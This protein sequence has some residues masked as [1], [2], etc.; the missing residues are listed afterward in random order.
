[1]FK[2]L[3]RSLFTV[4]ALLACSS[5]VAEELVLEEVIVTATK[6][7]GVAQD[8]PLALSVL[9]ESF[10]ESNAIRS[11]EDLRD[12]VPGLEVVSV[13][14][15]SNII[16][17]RGVVALGGPISPVGYY[18]DE[19]PISAFS[20]DAPAV[21]LWDLQRV[22]VLRG[23]QGTL[24]GDGSMAGTI[25]AITNK[26]DT[27][28]FAGRVWIDG[29][30]Y[31]G[32]NNGYNLRA[33]LNM[34][35][36]DTLAFRI[37]AGYKD[38]GGY[39]TNVHFNDDGD[40]AYDEGNV[41]AAMRWLPGENTTVDLS[42]TGYRLDMGND[43]NQTSPGF[44]DPDN[45]FPPGFV[46]PAIKRDV[47]DF[48][49]DLFNL[50][51]EHEFENFSLVSATSY[52]DSAGS[53]FEDLNYVVPGFF[54]GGPVADF[55]PGSSAAQVIP[56]NDQTTFTQEI[57]L[58]S[59]GD[60]RL[61]WTVG[62]FYKDLD[63]SVVSAFDLRVFLDLALVDPGLAGVIATVA[64]EAGFSEQSSGAKSWAVFA[65]LDY[66]LTDKVSLTGGLRYYEDTRDSLIEQ[67][68]TTEVFGV[69]AG[70]L[71]P[72]SGDDSALSPK[73][74][75]SWKTSDTTTLFASASKGFRSGDTNPNH[76]MDPELIP[77][78]YGAETLWT[79]EIGVK[80]N[81]T[82]KLLTNFYLYYNDWTDMQLFLVTADGLFSYTDN[83]GSAKA[84][85]AELEVMYLVNSNLSL[86]LSASY[87]DAE[88]SETVIDP[89]GVEV[90]QEGNEIPFI[91]PFTAN[92]GFDYSRPFGNNKTFVASGNYAY[93]DRT[94][95]DAA[96]AENQKNDS[97]DM[98]NARIGVQ[99][100]TWGIYA[101]GRNLANTDATTLKTQPIGILNDVIF[102]IYVPP[103]TFGLELQARF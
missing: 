97:Y 37:S 78:G 48:D 88:I 29:F 34:P 26:P 22:E 16:G 92:I 25:R 94:F 80:S 46:I 98:L 91:A 101:Y 44:Y 73:L 96:N 79:Y 50:T 21:A 20:S 14:P 40:N 55:L 56:K 49:Y 66:E 31:D 6:R 90:A 30:S 60:N 42:Y 52:Y 99:W 15:S 84:T 53:S 45:A 57:R 35:V 28:A 63:R 70:D 23:P 38:D 102:S 68:V 59:N 43:N 100:E 95:S 41:R 8:I 75:L 64:D 33:L 1:M 3:N 2:Q 83:V 19:T 65:E 9:P 103:R 76:I 82:D 27:E 18:L 61:D 54:F 32:G 58:V 77:D 67:L 39:I 72:G 62:A 74:G 85:G 36:S 13:Q 11:V 51:I 5:L 17:M 89:A 24:F 47:R 4:T 81:P 10:I 87:I 93:K 7:E 86:S 12:F 71:I 69:P